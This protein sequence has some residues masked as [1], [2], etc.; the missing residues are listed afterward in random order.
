MR[1]R[2]GERLAELEAM[3]TLETDAC[4]VWQSGTNGR[5]GTIRIAQQMHY[6]HTI[7]LERRAGP[8]PDGHHAAHR[9]V[10]CHEPPCL[11][12]RHLRWAT[13]VDN[14]AD[15]LLDGTAM[16]GSANHVTKHTEDE[17]REMRLRRLAGATIRGLAREYGLA[18]GTV[19]RIC[20]GKTWRAK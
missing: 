8:R 20:S 4:I 5:Y 7:A 18:P 12:Y 1:A 9:P 2:P 10:V 17:I 16:L 11:N 6:V 14:N 3:L 13:A 15:K 19:S